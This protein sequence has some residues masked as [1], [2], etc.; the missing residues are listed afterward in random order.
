MIAL[1]ML[2][3]YS[4]FDLWRGSYEEYDGQ[5]CVIDAVVISTGYLGEG[6]STH[7]ISV[8]SI[9]G[10]PN[11]HKSILTC[12][13]LSVMEPGE[14]FTARVAATSK[15]EDTDGR[16]NEQLS[17]A[18]NGIFITYM[19]VDENA[20]S[21]SD[22]DVFDIR[23]F[24]ARINSK[25]SAILTQGVKGE[26]GN[27]ASALLLG[28]DRLLSNETQRDFNRSG[29]SH[30]LALSGMHVSILIGAVMWLLKK[31]RINHKII[32]AVITVCSISYL[33]ITGFSLS[34]SRAVIMFLIVY[35]ST[36]SEGISDSLTA[37]GLSGVILILISPGTAVDIGFWMS[38]CATLGILA[39]LPAFKQYINNALLNI[40][41]HKRF[42]SILAKT[43]NGVATGLF[44]FVPLFVVLCFSIKQFHLFSILSSAI[45]ALPSELI[46]IL[47]LLLLPLS[48]IGVIASA[49]S[50]SIAFLF[51]LMMDYCAYVSDMHGVVISLNYSFTAA[52]AIIVLAAVIWS[53]AVKSRNIFRS[54]IPFAL[55]IAAFI[56]V[57]TIYEH[58]MNK[59]VN[60]E[61]INSSS[62]ADMLVISNNREAIICD[63]GNGSISS[64]RDALNVLYEVRSTEVR[65]IML[66]RYEYAY[67]ASLYAMFTSNKVRELWLPEPTDGDEYYHMTAIYKLAE[68]CDVDVY[69]YEDGDKFDIFSYTNLQAFHGKI[70]RSAVPIS[71]I[72]IS[73]RGERATYLSPAYNE[74]DELS[75]IANDYIQRSHFLV[76]GN[77][78]PR[79]KKP[80]I[81]PESR[82]IEAAAFA[83]REI[84]A[85]YGSY[86]HLYISTFLAEDSFTINLTK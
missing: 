36:L 68:R 62:E 53:L 35:L 74:C 85:Y 50:T 76:F 39:Y 73:T 32:A 86:D 71:L 60:V 20:V 64:Y 37:L 15:F 23:I 27:F 12:K 19:S 72:S 21:I 18:S 1:A 22:D 11:Y 65:A 7:E 59:Y 48:K 49:V 52:F 26:A 16:Y 46:L 54:L 28:N 69:V 8:N 9:N 58:Q 63:I 81:L 79:I 17:M 2:I 40:P 67:N 51:E 61:Y 57:A 41:K 29:V 4:Y 82:K 83:D 25:L 42:F 78:G 34:A 70:D 38:V 6:F 44:A 56:S 75:D 14:R 66:T 77:K 3:S 30:I 31:L 24:S 84:A 13:Y 43:I 45:L 55:S 10:E 80:F 5:E 33:A 47:S